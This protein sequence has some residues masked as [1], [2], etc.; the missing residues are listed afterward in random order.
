MIRL[1]D[2]QKEYEN[3]T[4]ALRGLLSSRLG[5]RFYSSILAREKKK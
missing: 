4:H 1:T 3:G 2:V 5:E